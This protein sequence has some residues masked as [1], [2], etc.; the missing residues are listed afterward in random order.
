MKNQ[1]FMTIMCVFI[2]TLTLWYIKVD[3]T[4]DIK[5]MGNAI[6]KFATM[7][8]IIRLMSNTVYYM[9]GGFSWRAQKFLPHFI[10]VLHN[11]MVNYL[12]YESL[13]SY[14]YGAEIIYDVAFRD[15]WVK[16]N[17]KKPFLDDL[18]SNFNQKEIEINLRKIR[19]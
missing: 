15:Q 18:M 9:C 6:R 2:Y 3:R 12:I 16:R 7:R 14:N 10:Y 13:P 8:L 4:L 17:Q 11:W 1:R 19:N 5:E